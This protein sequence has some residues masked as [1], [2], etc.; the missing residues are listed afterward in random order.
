M[1]VIRR[2][3]T[4]QIKMK[5]ALDAIKGQKTTAE[6]TAKYGVLPNKGTKSDIG[7]AR[8]VHVQA[9]FPVR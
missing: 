2:R 9:E 8:S 6:I 3:H 7:I 1:S 4:Q 5:V